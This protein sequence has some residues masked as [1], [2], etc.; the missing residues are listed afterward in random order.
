MAQKDNPSLLQIAYLEDLRRFQ[1]AGEKCSVVRIAEKNGVTHGP[2]SRFFKKCMADGLLTDRYTLT[3]K[4]SRW[5]QDWVDLREGLR[6]YFGRLGMSAAEIEDNLKDMIE[7]VSFVTLGMMLE[8][9]KLRQK[10]Q[11]L[12]NHQ[13]GGQQVSAEQVRALISAGRYPVNFLFL[14]A[15]GRGQERSMA[16]LGFE[17]PAVLRCTRRGIWLDLKL[18]EVEAASYLDQSLRRGR[19][20]TMKYEDHGELKTLVPEKNKVSIPFDAFTF[21]C[22][23]TGQFLGL[24][25]VAMTCTAGE[26]HMPERMAQLMFWL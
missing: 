15:S 10:H 8:E 3:E 5:L 2:V 7:N 12:L 4:G 24:L 21:T 16:D 22:L 6:E 26:A 19:L 18:Q 13:Q 11:Q 1:Q 20:K 25:Y 9:D 17:K 23:K 14:K